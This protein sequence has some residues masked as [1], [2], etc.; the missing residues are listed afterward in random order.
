MNTG[1][2]PAVVPKLQ[3]KV[4]TSCLNGNEDFLK[5]FGVGSRPPGSGP[6]VQST[7]GEKV[8]MP[9]LRENWSVFSSHGEL[10]PPSLKVCCG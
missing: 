2:C 9:N 5:G 7:F 4:L 8:R 6:N 3:L 10:A 1:G